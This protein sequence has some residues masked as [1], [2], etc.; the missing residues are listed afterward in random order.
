HAAIQERRDDRAAR[1]DAR[2]EVQA[3]LGHDVFRNHAAREERRSQPVFLFKNRKA[4][5]A[6][7][8]AVHEVRGAE[9]APAGLIFI[10]WADTLGC[11]AD[12]C[13]AARELGGCL[14]RAVIGQNQVRAV[15]HTQAALRL[16]AGL[17]QR[18]QLRHPRFQ[19]HRY[20]VADDRTLI[21]TET[22]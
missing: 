13:H 17:R 22:A 12:F 5:L 6:E 1:E 3:A 20:A 8:L 7:T 15:T 16:D 19:I 21:P 11:G 9:P 14:V 4:L 2:R 10:A 18:V